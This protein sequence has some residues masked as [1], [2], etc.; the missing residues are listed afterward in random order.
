MNPK[1]SNKYSLDILSLSLV[2]AFAA[3]GCG[4]SLDDLDALG[5]EPPT[6]GPRA[7]LGSPMPSMQNGTSNAGNTGG[8]SGPKVSV[9][10]VP[11]AGSTCSGGNN[12]AATPSPQPAIADAGVSQPDTTPASQPIVVP[13]TQP[14]A[15]MPIAPMPGDLR[16]TE[17]MVN[18]AGQDAG[19]EWFEILNTT[20]QILDL[21]SLVIADNARES[22]VAVAVISPGESLV[23]G[24][25]L[26]AA[27]EGVVANVAYGTGVSFNNDGDSLSL[28]VGPCATG[29]V[30]T[31]ATWGNL[32]T[33][34]DGHAV[35]FSA[36]GAPECPAEPAIATGGF[37]T[38]GQVNP[39]CAL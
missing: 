17:I 23:F 32:G 10:A 11:D 35:Q 2:F 28:C 27:G 3:T 8:T 38:P 12:A 36:A 26:L 5:I 18:P 34:F 14:V 7:D 30:L 16:I 15:P 20:E 9:H 1:T 21:T 29:T 6:T 39:V 37:G 33:R 31:R 22:A 4:P 25:R 24:Q 19:F 13:P